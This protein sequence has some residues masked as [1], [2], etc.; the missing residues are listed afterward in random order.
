MSNV[1]VNVPSPVQSGDTIISNNST[2]ETSG[3]TAISPPAPRR[4]VRNRQAPERFGEWIY[5]QSA[6]DTDLI[7]YFV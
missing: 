7:E 6:D 2:Q 5:Q 4:S 3:A 1:S